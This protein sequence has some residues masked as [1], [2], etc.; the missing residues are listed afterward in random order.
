MN[1]IKFYMQ[2]CDKNGVLVE[3]TKRDLE[4]DFDG[5]RYA[6]CEGL[7]DYGK[8]RIYT[9]S[10]ADSETLRTYIPKEL[11]N[12]AI[13]ITFTFYFIGEDRQK[14]YHEFVEYIRNGYHVYYDTARNRKFYFCVVD[15]LKTANEVFHGSTPY[16]E[17]K[18]SVQN[19]KGK[20]DL[21]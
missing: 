21:V 2:E 14:T 10:Y 17:F 5:L 8:P 9:E 1:D 6:K 16:L 3:G 7:N 12:D 13:K 19:L 4:A 11:T 20:T 15:E 18:F